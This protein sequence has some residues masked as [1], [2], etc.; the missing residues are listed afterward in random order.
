V[1][2]LSTVPFALIIL[3]CLNSGGYDTVTYRFWALLQLLSMARP[4]PWADASPW[5][6]GLA[7][8]RPANAPHE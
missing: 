7:C 1:D 2:F 4:S 3:A 5:P 6:A 8:E